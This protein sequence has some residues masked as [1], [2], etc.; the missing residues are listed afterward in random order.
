MPLQKRSGQVSGFVLGSDNSAV[1]DAAEDTKSEKRP[2]DMVPDANADHLGAGLFRT[3]NDQ[4]QQVT[5]AV[6]D[7][8]GLGH[9]ESHDLVITDVG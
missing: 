7:V 1:G 9:V 8:G 5:G 2:A 6:V 4:G 3:I